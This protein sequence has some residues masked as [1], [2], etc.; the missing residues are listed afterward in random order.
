MT[1]KIVKKNAD[2]TPSLK[3]FLQVKG[4]IDNATDKLE[5][6]DS[7]RSFEMHVASQFGD[8][9]SDDLD[10]L[11]ELINIL[12]WFRNIRSSQLEIAGEILYLQEVKAGEILLKEI[13]IKVSEK[14]FRKA[15]ELVA[16]FEGKLESNETIE[17]LKEEIKRL[18]RE[19]EEQAS[20]SK[21]TTMFENGIQSNPDGIQF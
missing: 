17:A 15:K 13:E 1:K 21:S 2:L 9:S 20:Q 7:Y 16:V 6:S 4:L 18:E 10:S 8:I 12:K 14:D 5:L 3:M 19:K 11:S